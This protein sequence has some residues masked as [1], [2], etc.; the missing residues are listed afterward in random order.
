M[1]WRWIII[2]VIIVAVVV[3]DVTWNIIIGIGIV[4][5]WRTISYTSIRNRRTNKLLLIVVIRHDTVLLQ[6][7][8][9]ARAPLEGKK[10][11]LCCTP[12]NAITARHMQQPPRPQNSGVCV[13]I[14]IILLTG[15]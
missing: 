14:Y 15:E 1:D 6:L 4:T 9:Y 12:G 10:A 7:T 5:R 11:S 3:L 2:R 13:C 8:S